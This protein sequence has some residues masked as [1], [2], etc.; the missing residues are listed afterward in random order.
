M[1]PDLEVP[2]VYFMSGTWDQD[3]MVLHSLLGGLTLGTLLAVA[4]TVF[5]Y[6]RVMGAFLPINKD[7]VREKCRFS[8]MLAFSCF[9]GVLS[10]ILLDV[11]N[12]AY[13]PLFWPYLS[14]FQTPSPIVFLLG[15]KEMASI[16][17]HSSMIVLC[18]AIFVKSRG[19]F[20]NKVLV[21]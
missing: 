16:I 14:L 13:N 20:W 12:H 10:H 17:V 9:L 18:V 6:P 11:A 8:S 4:L 15:G 3:R 19:D 2:F 7:R 21:G 5:L 1:V